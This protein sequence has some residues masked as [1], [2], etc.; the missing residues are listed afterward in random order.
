MLKDDDIRDDLCDFLEMQF[1]KVRFFDELT[2]AKSRAD[3]VMV[4]EDALYGIEI[5]SDADTYTRLA[6]QVKDYN[7]FFDYNIV[8][9][10]SSHAHHIREHVPDHWGVI[11]V[12]E[13]EGAVCEG[14]ADEG[15]PVCEGPD[16]EGSAKKASAKKGTAKGAAKKVPVR[17]VLDFYVLRQPEK[18]PKVRLTNQLSLLWKREFLAIQLEHNL[19]K[20]PG[21]SRA[22]VKKYLLENVPKETLK[23]EMLEQ[24]F[25]RDYT[26]L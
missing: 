23:K 16:G 4:T 5:K 22:F 13:V 8:V 18:S 2:I 7:R 1:G 6:G 14:T 26:L 25:E 24:L 11:T 17:K 15:I 9:V 19:Y 10:G 21:K 3:I 12:E 20:Y